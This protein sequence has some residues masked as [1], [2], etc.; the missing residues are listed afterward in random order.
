MHMKREKHAPNNIKDK[1]LTN[2]AIVSK[3][4]K[5]NSTVITYFVEYHKTNFDFISQNIFY[6]AKNDLTKTF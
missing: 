4:N 1:L 2:E 6:T 3:A 5:G